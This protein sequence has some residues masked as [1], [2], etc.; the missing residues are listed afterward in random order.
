MSLDS[1]LYPEVLLG[2]EKLPAW[3][4]DHGEDSY[5]SWLEGQAEQ[6]K[7]RMRWIA[8][9]HFVMGASPGDEF[10]WTDEFPPTPVK[11]SRGFWLGETL[12]TQLQWKQLMASDNPSYFPGDARPVDSVSYGQI[13][14]FVAKLVAATGEGRFRLPTEA[15]WEYSCRA[16]T[17]TSTPVGNI[18]KLAKRGRSAALDSIAWYLG[19][20]WE[21]YELEVGYDASEWVV[22]HN[23]GT[24]LGTH[25]V[26]LKAANAWGLYDMLGNV[27]EFCLDS[28][29]DYGEL[30][31]YQGSTI[32]D[33]FYWH[34]SEDESAVTRGGDYSSSA[35]NIRSSA[36][37]SA[38]K[39]GSDGCAGFRWALG[40]RPVP[41][42]RKK[43]ND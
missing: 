26:G 10:A 11:I 2:G 37:R 40:A 14:L 32:V 20:A 8:P 24:L 36:R 6:V 41:S 30:S 35:R 28:C 5:G 39:D 18:K 7:F 23:A 38:N 43:G 21:E 27:D 12:C 3:I 9:G 19:N 25:A 42:P 16:G 17:S 15:E 1:S 31:N 22:G 33:P 29:G 34:L 13:S 4:V